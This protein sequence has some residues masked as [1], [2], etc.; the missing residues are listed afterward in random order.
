[1]P[2]VSLFAADGLNYSYYAFCGGADGDCQGSSSGNPVQISGAGGTSISSPAFAGIMALVNQKYGRQ[3]QA[4]FVLY[5]LATQYPAAFHD[6][7]VGTNSVPCNI[8]TTSAGAP[9]LDCIAVSNPITV[10]DSTYGTAVEG[11]I[12]TGTTPELQR[13]YRI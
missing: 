4:D 12:G 7:T 2:D 13:R 11:Q 1:M 5:P 3:G 10:T 6:V 9:P 8:N